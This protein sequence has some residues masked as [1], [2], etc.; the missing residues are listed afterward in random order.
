VRLQKGGRGRWF[1]GEVSWVDYH[2]NL[3]LVTTQ[4]PDFWKDLKPA[5]F[6]S[7]VPADGNVQVLRWRDGNLESRRGEFTRFSFREGELSPINLLTMELTAEIQNAGR[8]EVVAANSHLLGVLTDQEGRNCSAQPATFIRNV[9]EAQRRGRF[10]GLGYFHFYWQ[11]GSNPAS[12]EFL[13]EAGEPRGVIVVSVPDRPDDSPQVL[14]ARD[15]ILSIDGFA[16]DMEGDYRDPEFGHLNLECLATRGK[17]AGEEVKMNIL[18]AGQEIEVQYKLPKFAFSNSLVPWAAYDREP[19]YVIVGG[20]VF[21]P[22]TD[23]LL[24]S[25]GQDWKR[26]SPFRLY[27]YNSQPPTKEQRS[28]VVLSEVLPDPYNIGYQQNKWLV[29]DKVNGVRINTLLDLREAL[30]KAADGL[31]T[32]EFVE[33]DSLRRMVVAAGDAQS[34]ATARVLKRYG[35]AEASNLG[36]EAGAGR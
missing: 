14:K 32:V 6:G 29:L 20:L 2:A 15:I 27:H 5:T 31:H 36:P 17:W 9:L 13:G 33:S 23:S 11:P 18:R 25:W 35:I 7:G 21:Q 34:Q 19:E 22:L 12:L 16:L 10:A 24:M 4:D 3:A 1:A 30:G 8:G 28:L 26:R